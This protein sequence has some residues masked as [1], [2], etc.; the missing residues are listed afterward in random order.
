MWSMAE[1]LWFTHQR[2]LYFTELP[3]AAEA[4]MHALLERSEA[5]IA[6]YDVSLDVED[7]LLVASTKAELNLLTPVTRKQ[8]RVQ[9]DFLRTLFLVPAHLFEVIFEVHLQAKA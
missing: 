3:E 2:M 5:L 7:V 4:A 1:T 6:C 9:Q 8:Q